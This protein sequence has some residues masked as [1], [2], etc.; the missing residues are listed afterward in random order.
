[1]LER[2]QGSLGGHHAGEL[3]REVADARAER[4][5]A[6]ELAR[7]GWGEPDLANRRKNDPVKLEMA[8]RLRRE[9]ILS[10]Q[11]IASRVHLGTSKAA[12]SKLHRHMRAAEAGPQFG[13]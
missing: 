8:A 12:N 7:H 1:M 4:I 9:T 2:L 13:I 10:I 5:I 11:D 6:E 3:H